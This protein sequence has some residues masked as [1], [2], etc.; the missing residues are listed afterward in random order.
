MSVRVLSR[1]PALGRSHG[2]GNRAV[3]GYR[4]SGRRRI[5][6]HG[7]RRR[8]CGRADGDV[9]QAGRSRRPLHPQP[10]TARI[11]D[12]VMQGRSGLAHARLDLSR[13]GQAAVVWNAI[14]VGS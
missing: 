6:I 2:S 4:G 10:G 13:H 7:R 12:S 14:I 3:R 8:P 11:Q 9:L 5:G 1:L